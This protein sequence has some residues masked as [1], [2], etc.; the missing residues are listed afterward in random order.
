MKTYI[1]VSIVS[2][3]EDHDDFISALREFAT[4]V[5]G[6]EYLGEQSKEYATHT[7]EPSCVILR[8]GNTR[9]PAVAIANR[10]GNSFY[11]ANI[12]PKEGGRM[13]MQEYNQVAGDFARD[14]RKYAKSVGLNLAVKA[15]SESIGLQG[16]ISGNKCRELF[17]R[18][19]NLHP[20]SYHPRDIER[21]DA[22]ICCLARH[23]RKSV[24]LE[25]LKGWL[26]QEKEW[27]DKDATWCVDRVD[28]GLSILKVNRRYY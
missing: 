5:D 4:S 6:W 8:V 19:L 22:F 14:L 2:R 3:Y 18:Y 10:S 16:I 20:T 11:V 28:T 17:E 7:G 25:L 9:S 13:S 24:D 1:E 26:L 23:A 21:L 27:S 15:T 12:V